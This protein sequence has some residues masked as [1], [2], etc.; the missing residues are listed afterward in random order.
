MLVI[1]KGTGNRF[2]QQWS[3]ITHVV[4]TNGWTLAFA[5]GTLALIVAFK[6]FVPRI[7]GAVVAVILSIILSSLLDASSHGVAVIGSVQGFP[8]IGLP[9][10]ILSVTGHGKSLPLE[11]GTSD[12]A[13]AKNRRVEL[14]ITST[15]IRYGNQA[16]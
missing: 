11:K 12:H 2:E 6:R 3:T 1:P 5:A 9:E 15:R 14:G 10:G 13:R 16:H 4:D 7:P 8:P